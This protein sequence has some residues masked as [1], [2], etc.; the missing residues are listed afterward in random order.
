MFVLRSIIVGALMQLYSQFIFSELSSKE[1]LRF[2]YTMEQGF[3]TS[4][5]MSVVATALD[6]YWGM[7]TDEVELIEITI[8]EKLQ[9]RDYTVSLADMAKAFESRG[10]AARAF[11]LDWE[12]LQSLVAKGYA[13]VV[14]HYAE[15]EKHFALLLGF[16]DGRAITVDPARGLESL[17]RESFEARYSGAA[18][19]LASKTLK[20][21]AALVADAVATAGKKQSRLEESA[22]RTAKL[23]GRSW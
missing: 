7:P 2:Q 9:D 10:V 12:G 23:S 4:C 3:D 15:P 21:E 14:V 8:G 6:R 11:K 18:M 17:S 5:G 20:P 19:A 22:A 1:S 13:P 16:K